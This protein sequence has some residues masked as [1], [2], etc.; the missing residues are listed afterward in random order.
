MSRTVITEDDLAPDR[1][2]ATGEHIAVPPPAP[3]APS[4]RSRLNGPLLAVGVVLAA[5]ALGGAFLLGQSTRPS[6][7]EVAAE[8]RDAI[9]EVRDGMRAER[10][11]ITKRALE[12]QRI[13]LRASHRREL[14][15]LRK[16]YGIPDPAAKA[17]PARVPAP[18]PS[19]GGTS[20]GGAAAPVPSAPAPP[21]SGPAAPPKPDVDS[22]P[23]PGAGLTNNDS[24][25]PNSRPEGLQ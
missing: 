10:S 19:S 24:P 21:V 6:E 3:A 17:A 14:A 23:T 2:P 20:G 5:V 4:E 1:P 16:R 8:V 12:R 11:A 25:T 15:A 18:K 22:S 13:Q 7:A 9:R